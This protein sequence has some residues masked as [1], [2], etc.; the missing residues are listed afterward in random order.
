MSR[1]AHLEHIQEFLILDDCKECAINHAI[2]HHKSF[3]L[4]IKSIIMKNIKI[5]RNN[6]RII[7]I[8][9]IIILIVGTFSGYEYYQYR[10]SLQ[11]ENEGFVLISQGKYVEGL[12][13]CLEKPYKV[14]PCYAFAFA[15]MLAKNQTIQ[16]EFCESIS[17][18]DKIPFWDYSEKQLDYFAKVKG[19]KTKCYQIYF[20]KTLGI[21]DI[22]RAQ[23]YVANQT[24]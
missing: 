23:D 16:K 7:I 1:C 12:Q 20:T 15:D 3:K 18:D 11:V 13:K 10:N 17:L 2:V 21:T 8:L 22:K 19:L 9:S 6:F 5:K 14:T 4:R 24:I